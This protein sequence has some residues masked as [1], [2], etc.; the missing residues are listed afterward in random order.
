MDKYIYIYVYIYIVFETTRKYLHLYPGRTLSIRPIPDRFAPA[1][2]P[3]AQLVSSAKSQVAARSD[4]M[5]T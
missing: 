3:L 4:L 2:Q 5:V 1:R